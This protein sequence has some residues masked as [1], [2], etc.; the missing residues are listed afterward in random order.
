MCRC[1][2]KHDLRHTF[3]TRM[4]AVGAPLRF[5]Q[6]WM[7]H[8]SAQTTEIYADYAPDPT[9]GAKFAEA[10]FGASITTSNAMQA[11]GEA[12]GHLPTHERN[13]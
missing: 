5:I 10:A 8:S 7:G 6:E 1:R 2:H 9:Q 3:G 4:A 13:R 11:G 12:D